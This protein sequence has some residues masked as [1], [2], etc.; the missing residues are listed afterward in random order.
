MPRVDP[1]L[2]AIDIGSSKIGVL[3]GQRDEQRGVEIVGKGLAANRGTRKGNIVNVEATVEALKQATEEAEVMAG[4]EVSRAFVGVAGTDVRSINSRGMVSVARKDQNREI[5]RQD[6]TR[7]LEAA[8]SAALPSDREI[9]HAIPQEFRVDDQGGIRDPLGMLGSR[10]EVAV[11]LVTCNSTRRKTLLTCV[12]RAG[13]EVI[14]LVF[15]PMATAEAVLTHDER[16]L[17]SLLID[18]G[19]GTTEYAHYC[20]GEAQHSAVLP[21]GAGHFTNDLAMVLRT[22]FAEAESIKKKHGCC[23]EGMVGE[24]EGISVPAVAGGPARVVPKRELCG[25]LQP[26]AEELLTLVRED[27]VKNGGEE[28]LRGGVVLTGG[29][30]QLDGLLEMAEEIFNCTVR[31]GLPQGLGG[32]VDVISCPTWAAASGLVLYGVQ[33]EDRVQRS[34]RS[35][36]SMRG[37]VSSIRSMFSDLL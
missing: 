20:E 16:E 15:E 1:Y 34:G 8:Q 14:E 24:E 32:L 30:A 31:Y 7:V 35:G 25:I 12:N 36:I 4:V 37:M 6:I 18:V 29:G 11:H 21:I 9:L 33:S 17:G 27:L 28:T 3:I 22:P 13:I 2:V 10:L 19:C 23:L 26:R 5:T